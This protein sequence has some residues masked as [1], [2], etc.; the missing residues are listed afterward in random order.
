MNAASALLYTSR[1]FRSAL[2]AFSPS[3]VYATGVQLLWSTAESL[4]PIAKL[5][6]KDDTEIT[7][8]TLLTA[9]CAVRC[10][11]LVSDE[12]IV[13]FCKGLDT[14]RAIMFLL[15][16]DMQVLN[17]LRNVAQKYPAMQAVKAVEKKLDQMIQENGGQMLQRPDGGTFLFMPIDNDELF[18]PATDPEGP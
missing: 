12:S 9:A 10:K 3:Q 16:P 14:D 1:G 4:V 11:Q 2:G 13:E 7:V 5:E 18:P 8:T 15:H 6:A 17:M